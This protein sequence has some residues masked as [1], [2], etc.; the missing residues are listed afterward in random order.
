MVK[1]LQ[2]CIC[3]GRIRGSGIGLKLKCCNGFSRAP[4]QHTFDDWINCASSSL[5][6]KQTTKVSAISWYKTVAV[7]GEAA[8]NGQP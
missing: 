2:Y 4:L 7:C 6:I 8:W 3:G 5:V 1:M